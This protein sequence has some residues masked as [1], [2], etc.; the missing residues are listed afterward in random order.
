[1]VVAVLIGCATRLAMSGEQ[2]QQMPFDTIDLG[3][4]AA[5]V[6]RLGR[7]GEIEGEMDWHQRIERKRE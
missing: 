5:L 2:R 1:V 3:E 6:C 7:F 4:A